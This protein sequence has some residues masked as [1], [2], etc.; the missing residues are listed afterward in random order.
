M[1]YKKL[2]S[3]VLLLAALALQASAYTVTPA[4]EA[5]QWQIDWSYNQERPDWQEPAS[6]NYENWTVV[7]VSIED[8]LK[9]Y[10]TADDL[11]AVFVDDELRGLASP[12][13]IVGAADSDAGTFLLKVWGNESS[14]QDISFTLKYYNSR[15]KSVFSFIYDFTMG[16]EQGVDEDFIP[17]FTLGSPKYPVV[18]AL[19]IAPYLAEANLTPAEGDIM[20]AFVGDECRGVTG[21]SPLTSHPSPLTVFLRDA[22]E[23]VILKYYDSTNNRIITFEEDDYLPG[24]ATDDGVVDVSDYIGIANYIMGDIPEGFNEKAADVNYDGMVNE[25]D[26]VEVANLIL[27]GNHS[28]L[29]TH[30]SPLSDNVIYVAPATVIPTVDGSEVQLSICMNNTAEIRG[31][32]FDIYLPEG[33]TAVKTPKGKFAVTFNTARLPEYDDHTLTVAELG[34][35]AIRFLCGS[36]YDKTLTGTS[37]EIATMKVN[38]EGLAEGE[39]PITLKAMK[40]SETNISNY[41]EEDEVITT[42]TLAANVPTGVSEMNMDNGVDGDC[43]DLQGRRVAPHLS[44]LTPHPSKGVYIVNGRKVIV[45]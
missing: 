12:A 14:D 21:L 35:G 17:T 26:Y 42:F 1:K 22:D 23:T 27:Y 2:F 39:Y 24:D 8:A 18:T 33:M 41:Y 6:E 25:S 32:Q 30:S 16:D 31:F 40:L 45:K 34:D 5:P 3:T 11:L 19:D 4:D 20:A 28:P 44:P 38:I 43:Y 10:A 29:T 15:L 9:P 36:L 13:V 7:L 37:G